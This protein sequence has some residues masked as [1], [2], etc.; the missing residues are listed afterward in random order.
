MDP[1]LHDLK[2]ITDTLMLGRSLFTKEFCD[3]LS[4]IGERYP[5]ADTASFTTGPDTAEEMKTFRH[6]SPITWINGAEDQKLIRDAITPFVKQVNIR[7]AWD[8][9]LNDEYL[10]ETPQYTTYTEGG[11]YDFHGDYGIGNDQN[12]FDRV[13]TCVI[14]LSDQDTDFT[15]GDFLVKDADGNIVKS[16]AAKKGDVV[17]F[18]PTTLHRVDTILS[19]VRRSLVCWCHGRP[20][21][22]APKMGIVTPITKSRA[23]Y[24]GPFLEHLLPYLEVNFGSLGTEYELIFAQQTNDEDIFNLNMCINVG[25]RY[26][27]EKLHCTQA[28]CAMVDNIPLSGVDFSWPG[29]VEISF[30]CCG[31]YKVDARSY[32][33]SQGPNNFMYGWGYQD[34][35][36]YQRMQFYGIPFQSWYKRPDAINSTMVDISTNEPAESCSVRKWSQGRPNLTIDDVPTIYGLKEWSGKDK[37]SNQKI[38]FLNDW[39]YNTRNWYHTVYNRGNQALAELIRKSSDIEKNR[40]YKRSGYNTLD[41]NTV[42]DNTIPNTYVAGSEPIYNPQFC[43]WKVFPRGA[44]TTPYG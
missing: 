35:E 18:T 41:L 27:F 12:S 23:Q 26:A 22:T 25:F 31:G 24:V 21:S 36:Y 39:T 28:L 15:G 40:Y 44:D 34:M 10:F 42:T 16:G 17:F 43:T 6:N 1:Q 14:L 38:S 30:M 7:M 13:F 5:W 29:H 37:Y 4:K 32:Y 11:L 33:T 19:G 9:E 2:P 3:K 8:L 20:K